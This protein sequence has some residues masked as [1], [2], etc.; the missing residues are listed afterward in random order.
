M[1]LCMRSS[2]RS[3][4]KWPISY[5]HTKSGKIYQFPDVIEKLPEVTRYWMLL[6]VGEL[7]D[8]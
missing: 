7:P 8:K 5:E 6:D 1:T 2:Q 4:L 3:Q